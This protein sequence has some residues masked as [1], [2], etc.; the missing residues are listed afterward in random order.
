M[1]ER[2][3]VRIGGREYTVDIQ[4][5]RTLVNGVPVSVD[6]VAVDEHCGLSFRS[7]GEMLHAV[8]EQSQE[9]FVSFRGRELSVEIETD[10]ERLLKQFLGASE[11]THQH[12]EVRAT[13]PGLI[14]R[15]AAEIGHEVAKGHAVIILEAM[16]MENEIRAPI[17]GTV[18]EIR[19]RQGQPVEKGDLLMVLE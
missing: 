10:R 11:E 5:D 19:V 9:S 18:R 4:S 16:K 12:A 1:S 8:F 2:L 13:M 15:I 7:D 6:D 17:D 3:A 14:V